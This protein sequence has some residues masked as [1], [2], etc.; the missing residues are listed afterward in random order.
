MAVQGNNISVQKNHYNDSQMTDMNSLANAMLSKP[1]ELSPIIT[2]LAGKD[3]KRFP[4]S[5][6]TEG[7]GNVKSIDRLEYEYR[8]KT[9]SLK[10]RP[11]AAATGGTTPGIGGGT[12]YLTF[13]DKWFI[14]PYV[15]VNGAGEQVRIMAEPVQVGANW[16]YT[17]QLVNPDP[18]AS[19]QGGKLI[20][21]LWAQMYAPVGVDFSRGNASNW[22][23]PGKV[24]NKIGTIRKSYHMSGNA[25]DFVAEFSLPK[26][27]GGSTKL[28]MDYEEYQ[29]MLAFKEE[30]E[31]YYWYGQK[32]YDDK[33]KATM[34]DENGQP[35][36]LGPGLLE[37]VINKDTYSV[38]TENKIKNIIGDLFYGMSDANAKQITLYTGTGGAREFDEALKGHLG[39]SGNS[40]KIGGENR[41]ITGSGRSLG[42]TGYFTQYE[43]VDGHTVNVVKLPMFDHG[44]IAQA[45]DK[46][47]V[48]GYSLESYRMIFVDQSNYDGQSNL[49]MINKKGREMMR[50]CVAGSVVP[51]GFDSGTARASDVDGASVH[52][53]KTA[54]IVLKRFDT[55]LD[56]QCVAS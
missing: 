15:L 10:T 27:G 30:C 50:W 24:R 13:P 54:G 44:P 37:Q 34:K 19:L 45:R 31:M 28:W 2:H 55:S 49:Q 51:R 33:G 8:V 53:L 36:I 38:L 32:T 22:E 25:K 3:D 39:A 29:H 20:G 21:D 6:L 4:L 17:V 23:T 5:F 11:I 14:F 48:T 35:V 42:L 46:H 52:M 16:R 12:F 56:I 43:H 1:T 26:K 47:P 7:V 40:W 18:G 41:F 9:H